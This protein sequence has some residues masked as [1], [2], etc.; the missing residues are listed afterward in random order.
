[1]K[2]LAS[3]SSCKKFCGSPNSVVKIRKSAGKLDEEW[4]VH[5][6][7]IK[8]NSEKLSGS[9]DCF[10]SFLTRALQQNEQTVSAPL[11]FVCPLFLPISEL[12]YLARCVKFNP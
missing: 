4:L 12:I 6:A 9:L 5:E 8:S 2:F 3:S 11:W 10:I 7:I 1:M